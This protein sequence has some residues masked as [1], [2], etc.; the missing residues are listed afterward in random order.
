MLWIVYNLLFAIGFLVMLPRFL[1]RMKRRGGYGKNF[2]HR[3][4]IYRPDQRERLGQGNRI[5]VHAVSVGELFVGLKLI[6]MMREEDPDARFVVSVTTSTAAAI[7][8]EK[9]CDPDE[10]IYFPLDFP[11]IVKRVL[12]TLSPS[13]LILVEG[14]FWPNLIR[15]AHR[16]GVP[17]FLVN[18][19]ISENSF[20]GYSKLR[21]FTRRIFPLLDMMCVQSEA[22]RDRVVLLGAPS[23]RVHVVN[24]AK[25]EVANQD[26][27]GEAWAVGLLERAGIDPVRPILLGGSTWP[28][29][30]DAL[31]EV[32]GA[33]REHVPG[34]ALVL[35]PRHAERRQ[36]VVDA[37]ERHGLPF[38][39]RSTLEPEASVEAVP[40]RVL[41]LD[42]TGELKNFYPAARVI[43]IGKSLTEHGGQNIIE[44]ALYSRPVV[45]GPN[46]ENFPVVM[47][48]FLR[49]GAVLQVTGRKDLEGAISGLLKDEERAR[50]MGDRAAQLVEEKAGGLK[51]TV[52]RIRGV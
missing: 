5:W 25:Y 18:G 30:E 27:E 29:E 37:V 23:E 21:G 22:D 43:F 12:R 7:A 13:M 39:L 9:V 41:I 45:V 11:L 47:E 34:L 19:R 46:M 15:A 49:A 33:L 1:W 52:R 35:A 40:D 36:A 20:R 42:S 14:E 6:D 3:F 16:G 24:S 50:E 28:G 26:P 17:I 31:L 32:Y 4:G 38:L 44:P 8:R 48:D 51:E 2:R 10:L